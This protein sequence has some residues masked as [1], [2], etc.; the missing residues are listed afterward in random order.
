M[1]FCWCLILCIPDCFCC[2]SL[3][4]QAFRKLLDCY[5]LVMLS[6]WL[7]SWLRPP[8]CPFVS[9][10]MRLTQP[11]FDNDTARSKVDLHAPLASHGP[12]EAYRL[13]LSCGARDR[14]SA[15]LQTNF[16]CLLQIPLIRFQQLPVRPP[17]S[18]KHTLEAASLAE[19]A[20]SESQ[21]QRQAACAAAW[22]P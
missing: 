10:Q 20:C 15:S 1:A 19:K 8:A 18:A 12:T 4:E 5:W 13:T 22:Q 7:L 17:L 14:P 2:A 3:S 6:S 16:I 21:G 9:V 11:N